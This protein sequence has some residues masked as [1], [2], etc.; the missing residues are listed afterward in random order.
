MFFVYILKSLKH[1]KHY[2]GQTKDIEKRILIHNGT[3]ARWTKRYQP[4]KL[5]Y[6]ETFLTRGEAMLREVELKKQKDIGY[7]L[8]KKYKIHI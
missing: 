3:Q 6:T 5:V 8:T 2:I 7:F 4:W 1:K